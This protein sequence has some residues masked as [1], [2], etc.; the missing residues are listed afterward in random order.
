MYICMLVL[1]I[2]RASTWTGVGVWLLA[3]ALLYVFYGRKHS[4]LSGAVSMPTADSIDTS[5]AHPRID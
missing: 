5:A 1:E 3:G 4:L 2:L